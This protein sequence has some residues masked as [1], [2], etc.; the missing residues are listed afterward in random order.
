MIGLESIGNRPEHGNSYPG[1][2]RQDRTM[3]IEPRSQETQ[4]EEKV[5]WQ[6]S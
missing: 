6:I 1:P 4:T 3:N 5:A 2:W